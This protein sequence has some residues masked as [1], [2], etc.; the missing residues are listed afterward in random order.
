VSETRVWK[1]ESD[2]LER[3]GVCMPE[4]G[5]IRWGFVNE[6]GRSEW[7]KLVTRKLG[8]LIDLRTGFLNYPISFATGPDGRIFILDAGNARVVVLNA[9]GNYVTQWGQ[10]GSDPGEFNFGSGE[11]PASGQGLNFSGSIVVDDHGYI[12]VADVGNR[13]IQKFAP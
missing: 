12:Y 9:K 10:L 13:R 7:S 11:Q 3:I 5:Q 1:L 8:P 2:A 6:R 4:E